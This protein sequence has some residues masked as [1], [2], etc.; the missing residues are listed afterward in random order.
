MDKRDMKVKNRLPFCSIQFN[1]FFLGGTDKTG[2]KNGKGTLF[3]GNGDWYEGDWYKDMRHGYGKLF[4]NNGEY[5]SGSW[6]GT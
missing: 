6:Y 5:Y 4:Y 1:L 2:M 3:Y